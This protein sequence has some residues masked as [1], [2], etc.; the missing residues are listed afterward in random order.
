LHF[1]FGLLKA[2]ELGQ[3][4]TG[5]KRKAVSWLG[6][7]F[8][9]ALLTVVFSVP[10]YAVHDTGVFQLDGDASSSTQP[11]SPPALDDWDKVCHQYAVPANCPASTDTTG[12]TSGAWTSEPNPSASI[13]TGGGSKDPQDITNWAWKDAGGLPD[14]DNLLHAFAV[15]YSLDPAATCPSGG[16]A[17]CEVIFFGSDRLDN[18]GDAQQ[19]F[20]FLKSKVGLGTNSVGGGTG[21]TG[22][23][24]AG[25]IL[26]I[27]DFSNGGTTSTIT[28]YKWDPSCTATNKPDGA[29]GDANLRRLETS[30]AAKCSAAAGV[31]DPFCGIVNAG[32]ITM[33]W[34]F[35]DKSG[36]P[37]NGALNGEFYEAG[38]NLSTLGLAGECFSSMV[39]ETRS[40]T[41]TTATLKD[42]VVSSFGKCE[43]GIATI[44][45]DGNGNPIPG[46][47]LSIGTGSV[48]VKDSATLT[49]NGISTWSGSVSFFL[50]GPIPTGTCD[51]TINTG[52]QIGSGQSVNQST[53]QPIL[54]DAAGV[55]S[56][57]RYCWRAKFT[58]GTTGLGDATDDGSGT[59][60]NPECFTVNPV[61]PTLTTAATCSATPCVL[62]STLSDTAA[63]SGTAN[64]PG[65]PAINPTTAGGPAGGTIT[66]KAYGPNSCTTVA[67]T[68]SP[69][70]VSGD[71]SAYGP[72]S[73][74]PTAVGTY[75][76]VA[77]Y[78]GDSPNTNGAGPTA[79]P[80][81]TIKTET[82]TVTDTS[83]V[84]SGQTWVPNDSAT[85]SSGSGLTPLNGT[86]TIELHESNDC[87]GAAVSGQT[88]SKTLS[89]ATLLADRTL[90]TTNSTY[91]VSVTKS[92]SWKVTFTSSDPNVSSPTTFSCEVT[93]L[94]ITN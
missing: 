84:V 9:A 6:V 58:S 44:A 71:N 16:A 39:A 56:A 37:G 34:T 4:A 91:S 74:G 38:I 29:C 86:L 41:S 49:V 69:V 13:F 30:D 26:V 36:T 50:C 19:G 72:V 40:S 22:S 33:P 17:K 18:S 90:T 61:T 92:V 1:R 21:F 10:T 46:G 64:K 28:V 11:L 59:I 5:S 78:T 67:F 47:G 75:V 94:T 43:S 23:H 60:P 31:G 77:S 32:T 12:S 65:T 62:G 53:V 80:E 20:W 70:T 51:G 35:V 15:R 63:L 73:F 76:F 24:Q 42:F 45:K 82:I 79:C 93:S 54:S 83:A 2:R 25:D 7:V 52:T 66:F 14:K 57:G 3:V 85:A 81:G 68:S 88:Y 8:S 87:S 89:N 48:S 27:S 55:T